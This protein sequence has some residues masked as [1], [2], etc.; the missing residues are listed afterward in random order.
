MTQDV[1]DRLSQYYCGD[2]IGGGWE[3]AGG[4]TD[5]SVHP[6]E[7]EDLP[8]SSDLRCERQPRALADYPPRL[9]LGGGTDSAQLR[10]LG[11]SPSVIADKRREREEEPDRRQ[12]EHVCHQHLQA[13]CQGPRPRAPALTLGARV[14]LP[15]APRCDPGRP[16]ELGRAQ[17]RAGEICSAPGHPAPARP[18]G[19]C[20]A[21]ADPV[22]TPTGKKSATGSP[23]AAR[24]ADTAIPFEHWAA[25]CVRFR[26]TPPGVIRTRRAAPCK[27]APLGAMPP[28]AVA[29][30]RGQCSG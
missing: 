29:E 8:C 30:L 16:A 13:Q 28:E 15:A 5:L 6:G 2:I 19:L 9:C 1:G 25:P 24:E 20:F 11:G 4:D 23:A 17:H 26:E 14:P 7:G 22:A 21:T 12:E 27:R 18:S 10:D 3:R